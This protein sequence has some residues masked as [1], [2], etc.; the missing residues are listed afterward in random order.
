MTHTRRTLLGSIGIGILGTA[1]C[2]GSPDGG[3]EDDGFT[4]TTTAFDEGES[5][6]KRYTCDGTDESPPLT[7]DGVPESAV[8]L[9]LIVDDPDAP[10]TTFT[11]WLLWNV[12]PDH[13][14]I[15][16]NVATT[17]TV[18]ALG[19]ARQGKNGF[20]SIG[21]RGP[22][23]PASDADHTYRFRGYALDSMVDVAPGAER[24]VVQQALENAAITTDLLT[25]TYGR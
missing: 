14:T 25:G 20:Q 18:D 1:G 9:G 10:G 8:A 5:I 22:C 12:P 7:F 16:G 15:P 24:N 3:S 4:V 23:P 17:E 11:H 2:A 21:Y 6:P 13:T 19:G